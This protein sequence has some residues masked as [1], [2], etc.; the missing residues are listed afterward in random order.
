MNKREKELIDYVMKIKQ[1]D[2]LL[3]FHGLE[4]EID[5]EIDNILKHLQQFKKQ[6]RKERKVMGTV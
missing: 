6:I 3:S 2:L 4:P 1:I 5:S